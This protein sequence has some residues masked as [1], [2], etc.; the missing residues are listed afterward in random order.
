M[1]IIRLIVECEMTREVER[2]L[3]SVSKIK[4]SLPLINSYVI[5][6]EKDSFHKLKSFPEVTCISNCTAVTAQS[7]MAAPAKAPTGLGIGIAILD[8]GVSP[9]SDLTEPANRITGFIDFIGSHTKPYDDNAHGTH[10]AGIAAGNGFLSNGKYKGIAP[11]ASIIGVKVLDSSGEGSAADMLAGIQW[12]VDNKDR[13]NIRIINLSI[14]T[15]DVGGKD[16]LVKACEAA[17]DLGLI[18]VVAAGNNGPQPGSVTSPGISRKVITVGA[19]DDNNSV[20]IRG[21]TLVNFSGRGPTSEC[22]IKPDIIAPGAK[23]ISCLTQTPNFGEKADDYTIPANS[24]VEMSGT[25]MA[26]PAVS[27]AIALLLEKF[28]RLKP[29]DVKLLIKASA[30][31]M[32]YSRNQQGWGTLDIDK[33]L[34]LGEQYAKQ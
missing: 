24:Y 17:W 12:V 7:D 1:E 19:S 5:E 6:I 9:V 30:S 3:N 10:V 29:N 25:S 23:I 31:D 27:G 14:G 16:P 11:Q 28:P 33:L 22:I 32:K 8:T 20:F 26:A 18:V 13:Y 15:K 4:Y 2:N 21:N 34:N